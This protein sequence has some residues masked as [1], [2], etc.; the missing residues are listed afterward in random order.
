MGLRAVLG[1]VY[2]L[3]LLSLTP[4]QASTYIGLETPTVQYA[5]NDADHLRKLFFSQLLSHLNINCSRPLT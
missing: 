1:L 2:C 3:L 5:P 4:F